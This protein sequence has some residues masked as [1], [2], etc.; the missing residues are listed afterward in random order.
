[1]TIAT[2]IFIPSDSHLIKYCIQSQ[3]VKC[4][5]EMVR[6]MNSLNTVFKRVQIPA[7]GSGSPV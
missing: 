2:S 5:G 7:E 1:M 4:G 3:S 6:E